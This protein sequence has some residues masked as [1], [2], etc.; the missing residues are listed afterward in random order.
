MPARLC[1]FK[2]VPLCAAG[3]VLHNIKGKNGRIPLPDSYL[4]M[5]ETDDWRM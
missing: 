5:H 3:H 1:M 2:S 4:E